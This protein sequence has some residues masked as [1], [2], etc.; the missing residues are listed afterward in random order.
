[1]LKQIFFL[2]IASFATSFAFAKDAEKAEYLPQED[3]LEQVQ[4]E[5]SRIDTLIKATEE[6]LVRE[7][8]LKIL[9]Q[10][11]RKIEDA[12]IQNPKD[13]DLL[14]K[15]AKTGKEALDCIQETNLSDYFQ[16]EFIKELQRLSQ[17]ANKKTPPPVR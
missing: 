8:K 14:F 15:L 6:N 7:K 2:L 5:T 11:Y 13:T 12:C 10:E 4:D 3:T 9:I 17:I 16:P 1:M